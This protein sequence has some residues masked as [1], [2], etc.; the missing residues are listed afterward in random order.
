MN[1]HC[2]L[3]MTD[4]LHCISSFVR[5]N[6]EI[7][8]GLVG[9]LLAA[10]GIIITLNALSRNRTNRFYDKLEKDS[11]YQIDESLK[12]IERI[13]R[14]A[15]QGDDSLTLYDILDQSALPEDIRSCKVFESLSPY[16]AEYCGNLDKYN[17]NIMP[18]KKI[19]FTFQEHGKKA[20]AIHELFKKCNYTD[21]SLGFAELHLKS[22][23][24]IANS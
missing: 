6:P 7:T 5:D 24:I 23:D 16:F 15:I 17:S 20:R 21:I 1:H 10:L 13:L 8:I 22:A 12:S 3:T 11:L 2:E 14:K 9:L 19:C 18:R 4:I